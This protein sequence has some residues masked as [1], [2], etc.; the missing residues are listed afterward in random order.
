MAS[1]RRKTDWLTEDFNPYVKKS[2]LQKRKTMVASKGPNIFEDFRVEDV[3]DESFSLNSH[4]EAADLQ[5]DE[6]GYEF[7]PFFNGSKEI[8]DTDFKYMRNLPWESKRNVYLPTNIRAKLNLPKMKSTYLQHWTELKDLNNKIVHLN[9]ETDQ[10]RPKFERFFYERKQ[11]QLRETLKKMRDDY[12]HLTLKMKKELVFYQQNYWRSNLEMLSQSSLRSMLS[13]SKMSHLRVD[14]KDGPSSAQANDKR[15]QPSSFRLRKQRSITS[16]VSASVVS[17]QSDNENG[18]GAKRLHSLSSPSNER[19]S[20]PGLSVSSTKRNLAKAVPD[21]EATSRSRVEGDLLDQGI[22][23]IQEAQEQDEISPLRR[24]SKLVSTATALNISIR[25]TGL[26]NE[27]SR[28]LVSPLSHLGAFSNLASSPGPWKAS[29]LPNSR[30]AL[31][32][33]DQ[34]FMTKKKLKFLKI[35]QQ[36]ALKSLERK[37]VVLSPLGSN[38]GR[39]PSPPPA[40][41]RSPLDLRSHALLSPLPGDQKLAMK[42]QLPNLLSTSQIRFASTKRSRM[43]RE[44]VHKS[45]GLYHKY[46]DVHLFPRI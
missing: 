5:K 36:N 21:R 19:L 12:E 39:K 28:F 44:W 31:A 2:S 6:E 20:E 32:S 24:H 13:K 27:P 30:P 43:N 42:P 29:G 7:F 23:S 16:D 45:M 22:T 8:Q 15:F 10:K 3:D 25:A 26:A 1:Q 9:S 17:R 35:R 34:K 14:S 37:K 11:N 40:W 4:E 33:P 38:Y 46:P 18:L 41:P